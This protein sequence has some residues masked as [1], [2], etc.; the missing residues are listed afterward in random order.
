MSENSLIS[1]SM[2][3]LASLFR[4]QRN[5]SRTFNSDLDAFMADGNTVIGRPALVGSKSKLAWKGSGSTLEFLEGCS[6][7][8]EI[9][10]HEGGGRVKIGTKAR[11]RGQ[12]RLSGPSSILIG[13]KTNFARPCTLIAYE[14]A[15]IRIGRNCLLS[16]VLFRTCDMHSI[17][18]VSTGERINPSRSIRLHDRV[19]IA[20][21]V[22]I[23]KGVTI[24]KDSVI[25]SNSVVSKP[26]PEGVIA[27][28]SPARIVREGITWSWKLRD[29]PALPPLEAETK[30]KPKVRIVTK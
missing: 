13:D 29:M 3:R 6:F 9:Q 22:T 28:G 16:N 12:L 4:L 25:A 2:K 26:I 30:K 14:G 5:A 7:Y 18:D 21:K 8:G 17:Y 11:V 10:F 24:G 15:E 23:L 1:I 27:A 20:E 19:W